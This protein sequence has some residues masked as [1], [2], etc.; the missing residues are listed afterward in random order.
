MTSLHHSSNHLRQVR[1]LPGP[2]ADRPRIDDVDDEH[3]CE[4]GDSINGSGLPVAADDAVFGA[5]LDDECVPDESIDF[6]EVLKY[7]SPRF[8]S[9]SSHR[10]SNTVL[11]SLGMGAASTRA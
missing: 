6:P 4:Q 9:S 8:S 3:D 2:R 10:F 1:Q 7:S 5:V 11:T